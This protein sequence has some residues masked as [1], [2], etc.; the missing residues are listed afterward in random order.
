MAK[1]N[2]GFLARK[3]IEISARR[4]GIDALGAMAQ[5]LFASLLLVGTIVFV[6][7]FLPHLIRVSSAKVEKQ[8]EGALQRV[9]MLRPE[10][11]RFVVLAVVFLTPVFAWFS[12]YAGFDA[13]IAN[14]NY[15]TPEQ[16]EDMDFFSRITSSDRSSLVDSTPVLLS[17]PNKAM[18]TTF[19]FLTC[20]I[21]S[22]AISA[23]S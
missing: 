20:S 7:L 19:R 4:Y 3:N 15:M 6:L 21:T 22:G 10:R 18:F 9:A 1:K 8:S 13:D 23:S 16:R 11:S 2:Q 12:Q 14:L 17:A 5:G